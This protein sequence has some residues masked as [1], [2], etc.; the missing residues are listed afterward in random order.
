MLP[1][2]A[3]ELQSVFPEG[4]RLDFSTEGEKKVREIL[5]LYEEA[6]AKKKQVKPPAGEY[7][8][9]HLKRGVK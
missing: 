3:L 5:T 6:F 9:G 1:D 4:V 2:L 7:T 8:R